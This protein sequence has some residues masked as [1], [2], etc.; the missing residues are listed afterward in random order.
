MAM[1]L[2]T[3]NLPS[4]SQLVASLLV[5]TFASSSPPSSTPPSTPS[6]PFPFPSSPPPSS[7][8]PSPIC[9]SFSFIAASSSLFFLSILTGSASLIIFLLCM[10][11]F[12]P[13]S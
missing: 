3:L 11:S 4:S 10:A 5:L 6:P 13:P 1:D 12:F 2:A 7:P 8:S 9:S